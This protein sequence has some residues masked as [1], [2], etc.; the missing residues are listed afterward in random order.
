M[1]DTSSYAYMAVQAPILDFGV[2]KLGTYKS[3]ECSVE[4]RDRQEQQV[5]GPGCV[6]LICPENPTIISTDA[7]QI[8][9]YKSSKYRKVLA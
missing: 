5:I 9:R 2:I 7:L 6:R 8:A 3:L 1:L 4:N